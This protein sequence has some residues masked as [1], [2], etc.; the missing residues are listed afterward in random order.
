MALGIRALAAA[1]ARRSAAGLALRPGAAPQAGAQAQAQVGAASGV[2]L[3]RAASSAEAS[4]S[5]S[6]FSAT[7]GG[8]SSSTAFAAGAVPP[9]EELFL[10]VLRAAEENR[11]DTFRERCKAQKVATYHDRN[12]HY[13]RNILGQPGPNHYGIHLPYEAHV[14]YRRGCRGS[15]GSLR[16]SIGRVGWLVKGPF[17]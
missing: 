17:D 4:T 9:A 7:P 8:G 11:L 3:R 10:Q 15:W 6:S 16:R 2:A 13:N 5:A 14:K 1:A 12:H